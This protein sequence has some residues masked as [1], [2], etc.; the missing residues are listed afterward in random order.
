MRRIFVLLS[1]VLLACSVAAA[2]SAGYDL[3]QTDSSCSTSVDLSSVKGLS[4]TTVT[5]K[6]VP[7]Q[8]STGNTDTIMKRGTPSSGK[9][10]LNVYAIKMKNCNSVTLNGS[11]VDVYVTVNGSNGGISTSVVPQPD[12]VQASS[13]SITINSDGTF[14]SSFTVYPDVIFTS[15]GGDPSTSTNHQAGPQTSLSAS[16]TW[17]SSAPSGYP[18][19]SSYP[20]GGFYPV[21]VTHSSPNHLHAVVPSKCGPTLN[22]PQISPNGATASLQQAGPTGTPQ[23]QNQQVACIA[24]Q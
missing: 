20:S 4:P 14:S 7:I 16:G 18:S 6:G 1:A 12:S 23:Q 11:P 3:F 9:A 15:V 5:L 22:S 8:S 17:S 19:S 2:Q 21:Q 13:G 10:S 24:V